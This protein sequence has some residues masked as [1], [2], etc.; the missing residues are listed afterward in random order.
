MPGTPRGRREETK[1]L[2]NMGVISVPD[3][4][5]HLGIGAGGKVV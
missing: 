4:A 2:L 5:F 1:R 3:G